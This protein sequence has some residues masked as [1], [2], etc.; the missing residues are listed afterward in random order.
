M[1]YSYINPTIVLDIHLTLT[2]YGLTLLF[3]KAVITLKILMSSFNE[4][5]EKNGHYDKVNYKDYIEISANT[6][7]LK[8]ERILKN[9]HEVDFR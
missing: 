4:K 9:S 5:L 6:N 2:H 8:S 3:L 7:T 1:Y